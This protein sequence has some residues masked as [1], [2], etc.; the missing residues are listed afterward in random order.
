MYLVTYFQEK[1]RK[2]EGLW[3]NHP[4]ALAPEQEIEDAVGKHT[5][6]GQC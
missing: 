2:V 5:L 1:F 3:Q 4:V 6:A